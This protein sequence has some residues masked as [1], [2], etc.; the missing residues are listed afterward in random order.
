MVNQSKMEESK[1]IT[2]RKSSDVN[3]RKQQIEELERKKKVF[4]LYKWDFLRQKR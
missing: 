4:Y 1:I 2:L 3:Y